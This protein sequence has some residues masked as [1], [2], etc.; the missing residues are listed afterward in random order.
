MAQTQLAPVA[1]PVETAETV[2]SGSADE[3]EAAA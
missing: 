1:E 2:T 3:A